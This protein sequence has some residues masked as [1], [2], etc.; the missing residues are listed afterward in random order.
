MIYDIG[1]N[2]LLEETLNM[3]LISNPF[4]AEKDDEVKKVAD[5]FFSSKYEAFIKKAQCQKVVVQL[6]AHAFVLVFV[7]VINVQ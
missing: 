4:W 7:H 5:N 1:V 6:G 3:K 2:E